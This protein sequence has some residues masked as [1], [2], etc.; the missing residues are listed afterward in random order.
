MHECRLCR[1]TRC[2]RRVTDSVANGIIVM[3]TLKQA[4]TFEEQVGHLREPHG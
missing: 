2:W 3:S 4:L 1:A